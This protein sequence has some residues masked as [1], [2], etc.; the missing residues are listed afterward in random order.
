MNIRNLKAY[1]QHLFS[2]LRHFVNALMCDWRIQPPYD[3]CIENN[4]NLKLIWIDSSQTESF[5]PLLFSTISISI[6]IRVWKNVWQKRLRISIWIYSTEKLEA[7]NSNFDCILKFS[8]RRIRVEH[9]AIS[10]PHSIQ[11]IFIFSL[12]NELAFLNDML[13]DSFFCY[14][15]LSYSDIPSR[16]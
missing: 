11:T 14:S 3:A 15:F 1:F 2:F 8:L 4:W 13:F 10:L 9:R 16:T 12:Y 5:P 7:V 6:S